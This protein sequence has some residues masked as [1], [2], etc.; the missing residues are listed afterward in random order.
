LK[1]KRKRE[2][3]GARGSRKKRAFEGQLTSS[4]IG[5]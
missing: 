2:E 5:V 1:Y 4:K 3:K